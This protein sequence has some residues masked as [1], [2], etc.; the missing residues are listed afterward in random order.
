MG[1]GLLCI[2]IASIDCIIM[3]GKLIVQWLAIILSVNNIED[4]IINGNY[5]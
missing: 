1:E 2:I 4:D 3:M 5:Y